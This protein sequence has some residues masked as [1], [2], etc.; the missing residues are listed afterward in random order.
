M[1]RDLIESIVMGYLMTYLPV[2]EF[3]VSRILVALCFAW[4]IFLFLVST[5]TEPGRKKPR[6]V[7]KKVGNKTYFYFNTNRRKI[8][9]KKLQGGGTKWTI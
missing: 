8:K 6:L 3:S 2:F 4:P 7:M 5:E 9:V 1:S